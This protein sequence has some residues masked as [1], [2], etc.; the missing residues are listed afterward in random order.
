MAEAPW[1]RTFFDADYLDVYGYMFSDAR[2]DREAAFVQRT[3]ELRPGDAVLDL[4]CGPGRHAVRLAGLGLKVT[5]LDLSAAYLEIASAEAR[6]RGVEL[7][8]VNA[9]MREIPFRERF[10]AVISM[11]SSFGYLES[12]AEDAKVLTAVAGALKPGGR[13]LLDLINRE[14]VIANYDEHDWHRA[15][16]GTLYLEHREIDLAASR[17]H[18]SFTAISPDGV[19]REIVGHHFRLYT[20]TEALGLLATAG[21]KQTAIYGGYEG[22]LYG[23]AARRMIIVSQK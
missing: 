8:T 17:N 15:G 20:L 2:A 7:E 3:L 14:W 12:E 4:C 22:E 5:G 9:D 10:D 18:V 13:F 11:F 21:L 1:Y 23:I 16:D 19:Q 6:R